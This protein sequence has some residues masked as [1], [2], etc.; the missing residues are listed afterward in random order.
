MEKPDRELTKK[1]AAS[2]ILERA[3]ILPCCENGFT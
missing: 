2:H 1:H 3:E